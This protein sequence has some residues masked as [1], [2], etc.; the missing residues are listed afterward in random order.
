[1]SHYFGTIKPINWYTML[2]KKQILLLRLFH[3]RNMFK[4]Y[5]V[6]ELARAAHEKS[7]NAIQIALRQLLKENILI[8]KKVGTSKLYKVNALNDL[9]F[10]YLELIKY[11]GLPKEAIY[12]IE[13]LKKEIEKYTFYYSLTVFGSYAI[14]AQ[15]KKSDMD[16]A[17]FIPDK[18]QESNM[19]IACNMVKSISLLP[20]HIN[21]IIND[22]FF[23]MLVNKQSNLGK[24]IALKHRAVHNINIFYKLI[25][26]A[27][28]NGFQY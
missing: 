2:T 12:S 15:T 19:K 4:E 25:I 3:G 13:A 16:I 5:G 28:D 27:I 6:R 24:E 11:L 1:M 14:N 23:E 22:D 8:Q 20:L 9:S 18:S 26:K 7:N 10:T 17:I 21:I